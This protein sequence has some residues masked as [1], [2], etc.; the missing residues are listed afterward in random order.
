MAIVRRIKIE[1]FEKVATLPLSMIVGPTGNPGLPGTKG[2]KGDRGEQGLRGL[3]GL[4]GAKGE[5]GER[6]TSVILEDLVEQLKVDKDFI[7]A[8]KGKDG[9]SHGWVGGSTSPVKYKQITNST[10]TIRASSLVD[11]M[12]IFGVVTDTATTVYLPSNIRETQLIVINDE[13]GS[14]STNNITVQVI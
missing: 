9:E 4:R 14:A 8:T 2:S 7:A 1:S 6:G 12:N 11:G 3:Q 10:Y 5:K 13:T